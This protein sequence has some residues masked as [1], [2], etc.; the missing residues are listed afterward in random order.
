M[1]HTPRQRWT[2]V[3]ADALPDDLILFDGVCVLCAGWVR[4][5][6][7]HDRDRRFRFAS[8]QSPFGR[9]MAQ[10]LGIDPDEPQTNAVV[11]DGKAWFKSDSMLKVIRHFPHWRL[12]LVF[13]LLPR[14]IRDWIYDRVAQNR[15]RL[16]GRTQ[17]C[18]SSYPDVADRIVE[19][20]CKSWQPAASSKAFHG[21]RTCDRAVGG[22]LGKK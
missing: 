2:P 3:E 16:F 14:A 4:F 12:A 9:A 8:I 18:V 11:A 1:T 22:H 7:E 10:R 5:V 6:I 21:L 20:A 13:G 19:D 15:Y 17:R